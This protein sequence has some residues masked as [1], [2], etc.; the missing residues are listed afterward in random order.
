MNLHEDIMVALSSE[1]TKQID[2]Q[3]ISTILWESALKD[4]PEWYLV[5]L[6]WEKG[7]DTEY[8]WNEACAW[9]IENFGLPGENYVTHPTNDHMDF[10]FK[11]H[12]DAVLMTL[13][14][15]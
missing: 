1:I 9:A 14:W 2:S 12:Q 3:I 10:L 11:K 8:F 7:K 15:V 4:H 13:K 5:Q 6:K